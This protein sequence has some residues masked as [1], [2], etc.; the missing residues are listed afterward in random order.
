VGDGTAGLLTPF[1]IENVTD[2][3][4]VNEVSFLAEKAAKRLYFY[5]DTHASTNIVS[6]ADQLAEVIRGYRKV[7]DQYADGQVTIDDVEAQ[8]QIAKKQIARILR[9]AD[10]AVADPAGA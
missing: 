7:L 6:C 5:G 10:S 2:A 1:P 8:R 9:R 3:N 4:F